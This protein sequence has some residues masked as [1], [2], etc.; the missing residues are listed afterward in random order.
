MIKPDRIINSIVA[1]LLLAGAVLVFIVAYRY[2]SMRSR[3]AETGNTE[4]AKQKVITGFEDA[5]MQGV[6]PKG[7]NL[8]VY[9]NYYQCNAVK[10]GDIA[11]FKFSEQIDPVIRI[12]HGIPGDKFAVKKT[13][14]GKWQI[15]VNGTLLTGKG[16]AYYFESNFPPPLK[17]YEEAGHNVLQ[18]NEYLV[19]S[20]SGPGLTDSSNL[21]FVKLQNLVGRVM[22][23]ESPK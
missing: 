18:A 2:C 15:E 23:F 22:S 5:L 1:F 7:S 6:Y 19:F 20:D 11:L 16:G 3:M 9:E 13:D 4:C 8:Q 17:T 10:R 14:D 12:V 21:G